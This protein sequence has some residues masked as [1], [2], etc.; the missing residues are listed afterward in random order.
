M[1][2]VSSGPSHQLRPTVKEPDLT[3]RVFLRL[4][5]IIQSVFGV[6][7]EFRNVSAS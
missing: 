5:F 3:S 4:P 6:R 2:A 7:L 1:N